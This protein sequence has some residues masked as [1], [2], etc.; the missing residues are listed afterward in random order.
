LRSELDVSF[1]QVALEAGRLLVQ[2]SG[3]DADAS[4]ATA[5]GWDQFTRFQLVDPATPPGPATNDITTLV[6]IALA[7]RPELLRL[8]AEQTSATRLARAERDARLPTVAAVGM[9]GGAPI[10]DSRLDDSY[11]AGAIE[12]SLPLFAGGLY[13]ARQ[14]EAELKARAAAET[15][16]NG[17]NDI[18]RDVRIAWLNLNSAVDELHTT[19]Q[20]VQHAAEAFDLAD[21]RYRAGLSSIVELSQAQLAL[22]SA[23]ID[24][25]DAR[26]A[27]LIQQATLAFQTGQNN[28]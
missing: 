22:T 23:Q 28:P 2:R 12:I 9:A 4:L 7:R 5:L 13:Q 19:D 15:L 21:A 14:R 8:R 16:R 18:I 1:A 25:V 6:Q 20:L 17:E 26:Y 11:A 10:H 27:V 24:Q 3:N